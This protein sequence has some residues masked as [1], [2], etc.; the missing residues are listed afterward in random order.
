M[1]F[2]E[3]GKIDRILS[4]PRFCQ[5]RRHPP[6]AGFGQQPLTIQIELGFV[7]AKRP[8][9][10]QRPPQIVGTWSRPR[11][12]KPFSENLHRAVGIDDHIAVLIFGACYGDG[13]FLMPTVHSTYRV[14]LDGMNQVLVHAPVLPEYPLGIGIRGSR[15]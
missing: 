8:L 9:H 13:Y 3:L 4:R 12:L 7:G 5:N 6:D 14:R 2:S 10:P 15:T 11:H 1:V